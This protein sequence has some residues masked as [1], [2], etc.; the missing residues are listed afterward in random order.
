M[1]KRIAFVVQRC[2]IEV[3]GGAEQHCL[4][5]ARRL[6]ARHRTEILTTCALDYT[7]WADHYPPGEEW[8]GE[9]C[10][11]R[12]RVGEQRDV[13]GFDRLSES[14]RPRIGKLGRAEE[15]GW[16]RAQGPWTPDLLD[17]LRARK[18]DYDA[19]VFFTYLYATTYFG[20]PL[21]AE[22]ALLA[23]TA[24]DEWPIHL[25][26]WN[27]LFEQP[28]AFIFN[29]EEEAAFLRRRFPNA[30][31]NGPVVG[32]AVEPPASVDTDA[33]RRAYGIE[34]P[35]LLYV[36]RVDPSKGVDELFQHFQAYRRSGGGDRA[37][38][39]LIGKPVVGIAPQPGVRL[40]GF[41][42]EEH[43]WGAIAACEALV[44][45]SRYESL[46]MAC[47]EAWSLSKPVLV[48][49]AS[50]VLVAQCR[51][52]QGG[53]WYGNADEFCAALDVLLREPTVAQALGRQ[54]Q[55]FVGENYRWERILDAYGELVSDITRRSGPL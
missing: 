27:R 29:T 36:G 3:N 33:F 55:R 14:I 28:R 35:F 45:P 41:V 21:V 38:L 5:V 42:P 1:S 20:L 34:G 40:L 51:R 50:D 24:H 23:P 48:T 17:Y 44:M 9:V 31:L 53:L 47:L 8:I 6:A 11:R 37:E 4:L 2:G 7:T 12:F 16:M 32:V 54:G 13:A 15:E 26:I 10:V 52:S 19:F 43:K 22:K 18:G 30:R 46:S 25:G 39:V 49:G